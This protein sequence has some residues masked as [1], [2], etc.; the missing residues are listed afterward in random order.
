MVCFFLPVLR[1]FLL[2]CPGERGRLWEVE[3]PGAW[4]QQRGSQLPSRLLLRSETRP[5]SASSV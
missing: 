1:Q 2:T 4:G 5:T 3:P